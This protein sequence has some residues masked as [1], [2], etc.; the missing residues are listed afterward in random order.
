MRFADRVQETVSGTPGTG[1]ITLGGAVSGYQTF[2]AGF[3][4]RLPTVVN[5]T[6]VDGAAWETG[7]GTLNSGGTQLTRDKIYQSSNSNAAISASSAAVVF[8][9]MSA[10]QAARP[11]IGRMVASMRGLAMP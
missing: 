11:T 7:E 10:N 3:A 9:T 6:I 2:A 8:C 5:Y 4:G 1:A